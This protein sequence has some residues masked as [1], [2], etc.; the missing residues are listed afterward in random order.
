MPKL[1]NE[2]LKY[3]FLAADEPPVRDER[4]GGCTAY[5]GSCA[6]LK[7]DFKSGCAQAQNRKFSQSGGCQLGLALG[8][9]N[10]LTRAITIVHSPLGCCSG[11]AGMAG[12]RSTSRASRGLV[13]EEQPWIHTNMDELDVVNGGVEKLKKAILYAEEE[14]HPEVIAIVNGCVPGIIGDDI[15]AVVR[16]LESQISARLVPIHCE[17]F[18]SRFVSSGYDAAN[19]GILKY[20]IRD[21]KEYPQLTEEA[22]IKYDFAKK[23]RT[24]RTVNI[25][26]VGSNSNGDE[27]ELSR[28]VSALGLIP[29]VVPL[30]ATVDDL[31]HLGE[32]ALNV[33][34]CATHDDYLLGHLKERYGTPYILD[35]LPIG[36]NCTN[37]WIRKIAAHFHL[38]AEAERLIEQENRELKEAIAPF[39]EVLKGKKIFVG[40]GETRILTTADFYRSIGMELV[41]IKAHNLDRFVENLLSDIKDPNLTVEVAAGQPA[42]ELNTLTRLKPDIYI[43]HAGANGWV[44]KIGIPN[45][46]LF[47]APINYMG[48]SGA[49][50]LARRAARAL[51]NTNFSKNIGKYVGH[52]LTETWMNLDPND[53]IIQGDR[54]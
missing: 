28:L 26:N 21:P 32:A 41:G 53:N 18:K 47:G 20:L 54:F 27:V 6:G 24:S 15:D 33:S 38:E 31:D 52:P 2:N 5:C 4:V 7:G 11:L 39:V 49:F 25:F 10:S 12:V 48:Y 36:I 51:K 3:N 44:S 16:E 37:T 45:I 19:H 23:Y 1:L 34:I 30:N 29:R 13:V 46:P 40:G 22:Q 50:E 42:E 8:I 14:Y 9:I 17:G 43:G 35:V